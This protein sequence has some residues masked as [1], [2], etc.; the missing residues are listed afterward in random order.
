MSELLSENQ[1]TK[2]S[3]RLLTLDGCDSLF[4]AGALPFASN[5]YKVT[6]SACFDKKVPRLYFSRSMSVAA[7]MRCK[8]STNC[9]RG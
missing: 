5:K 2:L 6:L 4:T 3:G 7:K 1:H 9:A 8:F